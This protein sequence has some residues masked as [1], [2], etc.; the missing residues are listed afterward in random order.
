MLGEII[1]FLYEKKML[2]ALIFLSL[3]FITIAVYVYFNNIKP[4]LN[5]QFVENREFI[6]EGDDAS[7][8]NE[9]QVATLYYFYTNWC[10]YCKK[11]R[12]VID[13]LKNELENK[14]FNNNRVIIQEVDCETDSNTAEKFNIEG[15]PTIK[16][17]SQDGTI[18]DYDAKP[19][20]DTLMQFLNEVL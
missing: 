17:V 13:E 16:L 8:S 3:F 9:P 12:P 11:A 5:K 20:V 4:S 15:Y 19:N 18:Y 10:P 7:S 1:D 6:P 14:T 2:I